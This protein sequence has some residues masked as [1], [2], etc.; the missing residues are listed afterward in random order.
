MTLLILDTDTFSLLV[1]KEPLVVKNFNRFNYRD[2]AITI[3]T[4]EEAMRGRLNYIKRASSRD[5]IILAYGKLGETLE[6]IRE[7]NLV[8]FD[9]A[10]AL[11]YEEFRR[12][13]IRIGTQDLRIASIAFSRNAIVVTRNTRDFSKVPGLILE[14]WTVV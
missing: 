10:A 7:F 9:E 13:K 14:D 5:K 6:D 2:I 4:V 12:Q 8:D 11:C 1:R 3:V